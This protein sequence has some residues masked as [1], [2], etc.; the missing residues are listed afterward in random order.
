[1][2]KS[3]GNLII[4]TSVDGARLPSRGRNVRVCV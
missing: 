2:L 4:E 3:V 1:V